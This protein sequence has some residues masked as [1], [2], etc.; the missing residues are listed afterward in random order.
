MLTRPASRRRR[1]RVDFYGKMSGDS[2]RVR[3]DPQ[4]T[5][6]RDRPDHGRGLINHPIKLKPGVDGKVRD[7]LRAAFLPEMYSIYPATSRAA[8]GAVQDRHPQR[9]C[10]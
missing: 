5:G 8:L 9:L 2:S 7:K 4:A 10:S 6:V 1:I 3:A